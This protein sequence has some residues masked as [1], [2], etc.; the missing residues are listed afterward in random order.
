MNW[1]VSPLSERRNDSLHDGLTDEGTQP[2]ILIS[3]SVLA[4]SLS[5][6][7]SSFPSDWLGTRGRVSRKAP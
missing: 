2:F 1:S 5:C 7:S 3:D 6:K 4:R